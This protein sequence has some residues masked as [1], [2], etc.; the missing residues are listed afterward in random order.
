MAVAK[1][2]LG[3]RA[4]QAILPQI[5][6]RASGWRRGKRMKN[7]GEPAPPPGVP[8]APLDRR[9]ISSMPINIFYPAVDAWTFHQSYPLRESWPAIQAGSKRFHH[10]TDQLK[11]CGVSQGPRC[12]AGWP[13]QY[14]LSLAVLAPGTIEG[15]IVVGGPLS[16]LI[17]IHQSD[18]AAGK[19]LRT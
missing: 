19:R 17:S 13:Q 16:V 1:P 5:Q 6:F 7:T 10:C 3:P 8:A 15:R 11:K 14:S 18:P 9:R 12:K 4:P 2:S